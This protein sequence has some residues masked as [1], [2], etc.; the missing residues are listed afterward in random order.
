MITIKLRRDTAA[1]W[2]ALNPVLADG[3]PG[4]ELGNNLMK[5]GDGFRSWNQLP[6]V[7]LPPVPSSIVTIGLPEHILSDTPHAVYD[8]GPNLNLLYQNAKV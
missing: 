1:R 5:I 4:I 8:D 2:N 7:A 6:Y 3:E